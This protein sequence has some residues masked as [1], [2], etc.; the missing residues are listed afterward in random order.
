MKKLKEKESLKL[1]N[2]KAPSAVAK[3]E[4][5]GRK[6]ALLTKGKVESLLYKVYG[7]NLA[8]CKGTSKPKKGDYV[9]ALENEFSRDIKK[10]DVF[11]VSLN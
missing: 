6:V 8:N 3:L 4:V 7:V 5:S 1:H 10:Y 9:K 2:E 11:I